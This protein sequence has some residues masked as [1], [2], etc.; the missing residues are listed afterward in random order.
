MNF[1][2]KESIVSLPEE[3]VFFQLTCGGGTSRFP[4]HPVLHKTHWA[5]SA[6]APFVCGLVLK[7]E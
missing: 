5:I 6:A 3:A 7:Q 4:E 2:C 1:C